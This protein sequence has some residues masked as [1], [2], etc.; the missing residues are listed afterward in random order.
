MK[1]HAL[2]NSFERYS[3][4]AAAGKP[5]SLTLA[6]LGAVLAL[7][8]S[9][10]AQGALN[11]P[12]STDPQLKA[13][14]PLATLNAAFRTAYAGLRS[15][16]IRETSPVIIHAGDKM[17]LL[18]DGVRTE[19]PALTPRYHELKS[20]AHVPLAL[21]VILIAGA[22]SRLDDSQ[23]NN[24]REYRLLVA[25]GRDSIE[26]RGFEPDQRDRQLRLFD[27]S[28]A[29]IDATLIKGMVAKTELLR[30][31]QSQKDDILANAY[32]AAQD[33]ID[34]TDRQFKAWQAEMTP[35][36]QK[37]LRVA[38]SSV[39]M[40]RV[41]NLAMQYFSVVLNEPFEGRFEEEEIK[42][43]DFRLLFTESVFDEEQ[44]LNAIGTHVVDAEIGSWFFDDTQR[45]HR[46]L[47]ADATEQ[48]IR[49]KFEKQPSTRR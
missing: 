39:H 28:L 3:Q 21:Y 43:S 32:E 41:G 48:I 14:D 12:T 46:D 29:L 25:Q 35:E 20:V 31:T 44:I 38:V 19:A 18:K 49:D 42:D 26:A 1:D 27:R 47:L 37:Q 9:T 15:G 33:Q 7:A 13:S 40:P 36:E 45:M 24:L 22:G 8:V 23:L 10:A 6:A 4:R 17:V 34:T 2:D 30:F 16:V 11:P 5:R